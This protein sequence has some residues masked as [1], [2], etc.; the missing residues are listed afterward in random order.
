MRS[1]TERVVDCCGYE[2]V[3]ERL[4]LALSDGD[5]RHQ[6]GRLWEEELPHSVVP[7]VIRLSRG[8]RAETR[9]LGERP[10]PEYLRSQSA[11]GSPR[12]APMTRDKEQKK[13]FEV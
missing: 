13:S 3:G 1:T 4:L 10:G 7:G 6:T 9:A 2:E 8:D 12:D 11:R 5:H